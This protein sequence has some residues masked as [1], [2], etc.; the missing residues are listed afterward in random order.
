MCTPYRAVSRHIRPELPHPVLRGVARWAAGESLCT[1]IRGMLLA[2]SSLIEYLS[3]Q[4]EVQLAWRT[5]Y[6]RCDVRATLKAVPPFNVALTAIQEV[7]PFP[8]L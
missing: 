3:F 5:A 1:L 4:S 6:L 8:E 7:S 2:L